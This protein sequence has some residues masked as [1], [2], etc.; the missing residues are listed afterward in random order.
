MVI[1]VYKQNV[2]VSAS[3]A[4]G[5]VPATLAELS[6][7]RIYF[8]VKARYQKWYFPSCCFDSNRRK[9]IAPR[10]HIFR[11]PLE[12]RMPKPLRAGL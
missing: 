7:C 12:L 3:S 5:R 10:I 8:K 1:A 4:E 2:P 6:E 11:H 9:T